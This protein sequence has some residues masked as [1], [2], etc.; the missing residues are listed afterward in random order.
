MQMKVSLLRAQILTYHKCITKLSGS[1]ASQ[2]IAYRPISPPGSETAISRI[3]S[4]IQDCSTNHTECMLALSG[5]LLDYVPM[6]PTRVLDVQNYPFSL[7]LI[8]SN[9]KKANYVALSHCWGGK[10]QLRTTKETLARH[11]KHIFC[12]DLSETI[13]DAAWVTKAL[14]ISYLWVDCL[15][16][17]QEDEVDFD[18]ESRRMAS[19]YEHSFLTIAATGARDGT[20]GLFIR[21]PKESYV[22]VPCDPEDS[23]LGYMY[24]GPQKEPEETI[25]GAP[26]N[27]RGWVLQENIFARR[28]VHFA[29][30][31]VYWE[32]HETFMGED[33]TSVTSAADMV[34]PNRALLSYVLDGFRGVRRSANSREINDMNKFVDVYSIWTQLV[35]YYSTREL[36]NLNDKL[37]AIFSLSLELERILGWPFKFHEGVLFGPPYVELQGL[38]WR[39]QQGASLQR[40][41]QRR[42]PSWSWAS[43][44]GAIDFIDMI[45]ENRHMYW[46]VDLWHPCDKDLKVLGVR[47]HRPTKTTSCQALLLE[48][49]A[50]EC[51]ATKGSYY[52]PGGQHGNNQLARV[53]N[54]QGE[55]IEG[56]LHYD[57]TSDQPDRVWL[58]PVFTRWRSKDAASP[59]YYCL[60]VKEAVGYPVKGRVFERVGAGMV[61]D[62][63]WFCSCE[64]G[65]LALV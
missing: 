10:L 15:C 54:E 1:Y 20:G 62:V 43:L 55:C 33:N 6:L 42:A 32:C 13:R 44:D 38:L 57:V 16:I 5:T 45:Y 18:Q 25:F 26:L 58:V 39:A 35:R 31:Q 11:Q 19:V 30:N 56:E 53:Y 27:K 9:S 59:V 65:F 17:I 52:G 37:P 49:T 3:K 47:A 60:M 63:K 48:G 21:S 40:P 23:T 41:A 46:F 64:R 7:R 28:T 36:T 29:S 12:E 4:W 51:F 24:L 61:L 22:E 50:L 34:F 14:D 2:H 8:I